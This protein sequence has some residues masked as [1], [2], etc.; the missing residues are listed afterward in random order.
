[1][2]SVRIKIAGMS[3]PGCVASL[4][5]VLARLAGVRIN[6]VAMDHADLDYDEAQASEATLKDAVARAGF[7]AVAVDGV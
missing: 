6:T 2:R 4:S 7:E 3:C 1:M 5:R